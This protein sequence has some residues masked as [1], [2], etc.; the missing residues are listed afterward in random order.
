M[1]QP[2]N[3]PSLGERATVHALLVGDRIDT[4]TLET[5]DALSTT[6]LA[7]RAG[8]K[9]IAVVFRYG[10]VVFVNMEP[11]EEKEYL[12]SLRGRI[13][14]P[15]KSRDDE[16]ATVEVAAEDQIPPGGPIGV[17]E[18]SIERLLLVAYALADSVVLAHDEREVA[19]VFERIEPF[20]RELGEEGRVSAKRSDVLRVIGNALLVQHR[21]SGRV[22]V[23]EDPDVLW[24]RVD[25]ERLYSRLKDE[26][27]LAE[28]VE[29]LNNKLTVIAETARALAELMDSARGL[30]LEL[31]IVLLIVF[32]IGI[33]LWQMFSGWG[34]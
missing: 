22:A 8:A 20:A 27:E 26:Y 31:M 3:L 11:R 24:D 14:G 19:A 16:T 15:L 4:A 21:V 34:H 13:S 30:R 10:V 9:G 17:K 32:E 28:R 25:L 23:G 33:T 1:D 18:M 2:T 5:G 7:F 12:R 29:G 6:P